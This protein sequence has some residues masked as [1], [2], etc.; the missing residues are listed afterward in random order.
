MVSK[1]E[2]NAR[3][4]MIQ[5]LI[6]KGKLR[7]ASHRT[8]DI[9]RLNAHERE[10]DIQLEGRERAEFLADRDIDREFNKPR[11]NSKTSTLESAVYTNTD[12]KEK[13]LSAKETLTNNRLV[14]DV[15]KSKLAYVLANGAENLETLQ[16]ASKAWLRDIDQHQVT[17]TAAYP[18]GI[19]HENMLEA[20]EIL[21]E[22]NLEFKDLHAFAIGKEGKSAILDKSLYESP[23]EL[24]NQAMRTHI[25]NPDGSRREKKAAPIHDISYNEMQEIRHEKREAR[26]RELEAN[27]KKQEEKKKGFFQRAMDKVPTKWRK[28]QPDNISKGLTQAEIEMIVDAR[29]NERLAE[30]TTP[31]E[32]AM[33][34]NE[35][36][37][38]KEN[39]KEGIK[40]DLSGEKPKNLKKEDVTLEDVLHAG[41][42]GFPTEKQVDKAVNTRHVQ[43]SSTEPISIEDKAKVVSATISAEKGLTRQQ[44][45]E[46]DKA[47]LTQTKDVKLP[48]LS[49]LQ[50]DDP[51]ADIPENIKTAAQVAQN[52]YNLKKERG[53]IKQGQLPSLPA[54][55]QP[56]NAASQFDALH[57]QKTQ[58]KSKT[59]LP[60]YTE[61]P[62]ANDMAQFVENKQRNQEIHVSKDGKTWNAD[63]HFNTMKECDTFIQD[64]EI[65]PK[66]NESAYM[67]FIAPDKRENGKTKSLKYQMAEVE[68]DGQPNQ[69]G[70]M[71]YRMKHNGQRG[72]MRA[73]SKLT[74]A[75]TKE[76]AMAIV[77]AKLDK[78]TLSLHTLSKG[79]TKD[80][81]RIQEQSANQQW[82]IGIDKTMERIASHENTL[83][84][85]Q[86][87]AQ[88]LTPKLPKAPDLDGG[89]SY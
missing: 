28:N 40:R 25:P 56:S 44:R 52:Q 6:A 5:Q 10:N 84:K 85:N 22:R 9:I 21:D 76:N 29:V 18:N 55:K 53:L 86:K 81:A 27:P 38:R 64:H 45:K 77:G 61:N 79:Q 66:A 63:T 68:F 30:M 37:L 14:N 88:N 4:K 75:A 33:T 26:R 31:K 7:E 36:N 46:R 70:G 47:L 62:H 13:E 17:N 16:E 67:V 34:A 11:F 71:G 59:M 15:S 42:P 41:E 1:K 3:F 12:K 54:Q 24:H 78:T 48:P 57:N 60:R 2:R 32:G 69:D 80:V 35:Q 8:M 89:L 83:R 23:D 39:L 50:P 19:P 43:S 20:Q 49:S 58:T 72:I 73:E 74:V 87:D 65:Q 82:S 51:H